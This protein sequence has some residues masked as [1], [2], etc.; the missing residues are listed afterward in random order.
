MY[1]DIYPR[2]G[3]L[4]ISLMF[5]FHTYVSNMSTYVMYTWI[6][7]CLEQNVKICLQIY[8][9]DLVH[10]TFASDSHFSAIP[11]SK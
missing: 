11:V 10:V 7:T 1:I 4:D 8:T 2:L 9:C 5:A 3:A 6:N